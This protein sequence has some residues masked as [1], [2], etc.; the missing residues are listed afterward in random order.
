MKEHAAR[1]FEY[2]NDCTV[3]EWMAAR[4]AQVD[5]LAGWDPSAPVGSPQHPAIMVDG[6]DL[7]TPRAAALSTAQIPEKGL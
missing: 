1:S 5:A 6:E 3:A 4:Q 2:A 7:S